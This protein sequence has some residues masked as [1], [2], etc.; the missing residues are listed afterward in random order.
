MASQEHRTATQSD[1]IY[2]P[3]PEKY[4]AA[5]EEKLFLKRFPL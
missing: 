3:F 5:L 2:S 1:P 4:L